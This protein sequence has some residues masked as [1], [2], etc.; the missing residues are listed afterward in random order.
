M[1]VLEV[2]SFLQSRLECHFLHPGLVSHAPLHVLAHLKII[3]VQA[4]HLF[5][6]AMQNY[7]KRDAK[8]CQE[9]PAVQVK[10]EL[11]PS[12]ATVIGGLGRI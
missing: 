11:H 2:E 9:P 3:T 6:A 5:N 4:F 10:E 7:S 1:F 12:K 8:C